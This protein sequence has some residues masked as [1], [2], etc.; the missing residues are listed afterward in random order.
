MEEAQGDLQIEDCEMKGIRAVLPFYLI[1]FL[2]VPSISL[3]WQGNVIN[4]HDGDTITVMHNGKP[5]KIRLYGIDTPELSQYSGQNAKQFTSSQVFDKLVQVQLIDKDRYGR[6]VGIVSVGNLVINRLLVEYGYAWVYGRYCKESFCKEW[7]DLEAL[8]KK[9]RRGLWKNPSAIPPWEYRH[10]KAM[11]AV[12]K[13]AV[14]GTP[15]DCSSNRY[16][17]PD[18]KTQ[19]EAQRC[20][21]YCLKVKGYDVHKLDRDKDGR[22]CESLP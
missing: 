21:E 22:A 10:P 7:G 16:N 11:A 6:T 13:A 8:A 3:A 20:Y 19:E 2:F 14:Q 12:K 5:E 15:C 18:F 1:V 4:V 9:K 17:C